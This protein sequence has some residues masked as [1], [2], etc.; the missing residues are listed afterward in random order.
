MNLGFLQ[1]DT[2]NNISSQQIA[3]K[4]IEIPNGNRYIWEFKNVSI[5]PGLES[6]YISYD[7]SYNNPMLPVISM[8]DSFI[9]FLLLGIIS[10]I[11][12]IHKR[13]I[14]KNVQSIY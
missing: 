10:L 11:K 9:V 2:Y 5:P 7:G 3:F 8:G 4:I 1:P 14:I 6:V 12:L 13:L